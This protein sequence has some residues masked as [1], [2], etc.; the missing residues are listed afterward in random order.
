MVIELLKHGRLLINYRFWPLKNRDPKNNLIIILNL[1]SFPQGYCECEFLQRLTWCNIFKVIRS[2]LSGNGHNRVFRP[3]LQT[4]LHSHST[5]APLNNNVN[6]F[7]KKGDKMQLCF[8]YRQKID[9]VDQKEKKRTRKSLSF[10]CAW[11][12]TLVI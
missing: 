11:S 8:R 9:L 6:S 4:S 12:T 3:L 2:F 7:N 1:L 5:F 10:F